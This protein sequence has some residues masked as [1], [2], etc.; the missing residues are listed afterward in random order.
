[1]E[2]DAQTLRLEPSDEW[3][4]VEYVLPR[5]DAD[6]E[7]DAEAERERYDAQIYAALVAPSF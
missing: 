4:A 2:N 1:M 5:A 7:A 3:L 6:L